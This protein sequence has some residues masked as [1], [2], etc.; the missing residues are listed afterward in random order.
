MIDL[1]ELQN[2]QVVKLNL[3][4]SSWKSSKH[5]NWIDCFNP[6]KEE[7]SLLA[8][9]FGLLVADLQKSIHPRQRS[10]LI[11]KNN[12][13]L[14]TF[15]GTYSDVKIKTAPIGI[16]VFKNKIITIHNKPL[17]GFNQL[18]E[19]PKEEFLHLFKKDFSY[20]LFKLI[21]FI[22]EDFFVLMEKIGEDIEKIEEDVLNV[23]KAT[24]INIFSQKHNLINLQKSLLAN[25]AAI[26]SLEKEYLRNYSKEEHNWFMELYN[27]ANQLVDVSA[28]Y[29]EMLTNALDVYLSSVNTNI[30]RTMKTLTAL[31]AFVLVPTLISSIYGMN[32]QKVSP[33]NMPELYWN[34]GYFFALGMILISII[35]VYIF[36]KKKKL[37]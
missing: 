30:N 1:W 28:T 17:N 11:F 32:F 2:N 8:K 10:Y 37:L 14:I 7:L 20:F 27:D 34:Y 36:F 16:F 25:R 31:S 19:L 29:H 18:R 24:E 15:R 6:T 22:Q 21:N 4:T 5:I 9:E 13:Y 35:L 33:W 3:K 26:S 12:H 23:K